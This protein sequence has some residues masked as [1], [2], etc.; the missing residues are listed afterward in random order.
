MA[1]TLRT[2]PTALDVMFQESMEAL[3]HHFK[4][5]TQG[6]QIPPGATYTAVEAPKGQYS[7]DRVLIHA[8][9][10]PPSL[11]KFGSWIF[12]AGEFGLYMVS[13]GTTKP[14]RCKIR[15]PGFAH[16]SCLE[17][18]SKDNFLADMVAVIGEYCLLNL[19]HPS[20]IFV[21]SCTFFVQE[22]WIL[23]SEKSIVSQAI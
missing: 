6:Y 8:S 10:R 21:L 12:V 16:L 14:Y 11:V 3:I 7:L 20:W 23:C 18:M 4:L 22:R 17:Q 9:P 15:A 2:Y 1:S 19:N 13:D 5:F